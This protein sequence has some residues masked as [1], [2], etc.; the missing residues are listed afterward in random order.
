[1]VWR[2][3]ICLFPF[4]FSRCW[5]LF[6]TPIICYNG[7]PRPCDRMADGHLMA[8][9]I[10]LEHLQIFLCKRFYSCIYHVISEIYLLTD[11]HKPIQKMDSMDC[12]STCIRLLLSCLQIYRKSIFKKIVACI[13]MF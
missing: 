10:M 5:P 7:F 8:R 1:M 6:R 12:T 9:T 2:V 4:D 11:L 13:K 3:K